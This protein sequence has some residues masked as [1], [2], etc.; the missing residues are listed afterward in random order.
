MFEEASTKRIYV[1]KVGQFTLIYVL[2]LACFFALGGLYLVIDTIVSGALE[3]L[4]LAV[5]T[6]VVC[7]LGVALLFRW[8]HKDHLSSQAVI[9][10]PDKV[11]L[12]MTRGED[13]KDYLFLNDVLG[14][15]IDND[16]QD[17]GPA[18]IVTTKSKP[19]AYKSMYFDRYKSFEDFCDRFERALATQNSRRPKAQ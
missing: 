13:D 7:L 8:L 4:P 9:L 18:L 11:Q 5:L 3:D 14:T 1:Y 15:K 19:V 12:P 16:Y 17:H 2:F 6:G 10:C